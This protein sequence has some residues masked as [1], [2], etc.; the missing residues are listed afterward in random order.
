MSAPLHLSQVLEEEY[1]ALHGP[2]PPEERTWLLWPEHITDAAA[3][4]ARLRDPAYP[5]SA[6]LQRQLPGGLPARADAAALAATL[7]RLL[8]ATQVLYDVH[9]LDG[10][11]VDEETTTLSSQNPQGDDLVHG[12]EPA[13][14][15][16][17]AHRS[18]DFP[19]EPTTDQWFS[20][21]QFES[22]RRL[23]LWEVETIIRDGAV[24]DL[25]G[26][27]ARAQEHV[28]ATQ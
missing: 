8:Q 27:V 25:N 28:Q 11:G 15:V 7:N 23:G 9:L 5:V 14:I 13:D 17:Y 22:Y 6:A 18:P 4:L 21:S 2:L 20:E 26:F 19:Q 24:P 12:N 16:A 1:A 3:L 10:G